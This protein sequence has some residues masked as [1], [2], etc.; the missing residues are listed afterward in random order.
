MNKSYILHAKI[1]Q[2]E[3]EE[4]YFVDAPLVGIYVTHG[5]FFEVKEVLWELPIRDVVSW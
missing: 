3:F 2:E 1:V 4:D 5:Y